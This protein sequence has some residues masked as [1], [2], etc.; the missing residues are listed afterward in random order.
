VTSPRNASETDKGRVYYWRGE[1][2]VSVTNVCGLLNKP[3]LVPS[4]RKI[5]V[6]TA[7]FRFPEWAPM[8]WAGQMEQ[9]R[10][11]ATRAARDVWDAKTARGSEI[12]QRIEDYLKSGTVVRG[13]LAF[14]AFREWERWGFQT[15]HSEVTI[16][17]R[18]YGYAGTVD[19]LGTLAADS[20]ILDIKSGGVWPEHALQLNA[21][22]NAEF[23][24]IDG[25]EVPMPKID[26]VGVLSVKEDSCTLVPMEL[27]ERVFESFVAL[28]KAWDFQ[29]LIAPEVIL[30]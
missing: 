18:K 17:S 10:M 30:S 8:I 21:Y 19:L 2:F 28:R 9:A 14:D 27:S 4:A 12:H 6:E 22:A 26:R 11:A 3:A 5:A 1:Q 29:Y 15:V 24:D 20:M 23:M 7:L 25:E 13:D 16:Y